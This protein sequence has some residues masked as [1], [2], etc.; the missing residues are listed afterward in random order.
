MDKRKIIKFGKS[1][2]IISLPRKW[3]L[4]NNLSFGDF[5]FISE[6]GP[7]L[8]IMPDEKKEKKKTKRVEID[9]SRID[10]REINRRIV[11][12][13]ISNNNVIKIY[14]SGLK[15]KADYIR[16]AIKNLMAIEIVQESS[17]SILAKDFLKIED[18][19]LSDLVRRMDIITRSLMQDMIG[20]PDEDM[21]KSI[22]ER[23]KD[24]NRLSFLLFRVI[25]YMLDHPSMAGKKGI[26]NRHMMVYDSMAHYIE[27]I[28]DDIKKISDMVSKKNLQKVITDNGIEEYFRKSHDLYVR[29]MTSFYKEDKEAAFSIS[30]TKNEMIGELEKLYQDTEKVKFSP[31]V[32]E[33]IKDIVLVCN[34]IARRIFM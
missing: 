27:R 26:S 19:S 17:N 28:A 34:S 16:K 10:E 2:S 21:V 7:N 4:Q 5:V 13:Y 20:L 29:A 12:A 32:L 8:M 25:N 18:V 15:D 24:I 9:I 33:K 11:S 6:M 3:L 22:Y 14:G 31:V 1:S 23:D 30:N